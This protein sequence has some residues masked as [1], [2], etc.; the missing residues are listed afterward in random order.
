MTPLATF[1]TPD[2]RFDHIHIDIVGPLPP[3]NGFSYLLTCIDRFTRWVEAIPLVNITADS[4]SQALVSGWISRFGVPSHITTDR[5]RQFESALFQNLLQTFGSQR[6]RTT[7]YHPIANGMVERFHR[8]LKAALKSH[9]AELG[10]I[11]SL[12]L[13]LLGIRSALKEDIG[14]TAAEL[15]Y[16]TTLRLPG[17]YFVGTSPTLPPVSEYVQ[18]LKSTMSSLRAAPPRPASRV[19]YVSPDLH[20]SQFVFVRTDAIR[21]LLQPPYKGPNA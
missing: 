16:G 11:K 21:K 3:S 13:V 10:W 12:P 18:Q 5:G 17:S 20:T 4:V 9:S 15:V 2:S 8:Q 1:F 7:S 19:V 6:F 14:C